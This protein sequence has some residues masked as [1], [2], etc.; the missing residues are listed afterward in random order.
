MIIAGV[1]LETTGLNTAED[2]I[3]EIGLVCWDTEKKIPLG[4]FSTFVDPGAD[5][6]PLKAEAK[7]KNKIE[8]E[9]LT[10][11]GMEPSTALIY[12]SEILH[13]FGVEHIVGHNCENYD[14]PL[15]MAEL[16]RNKIIGHLAERTPWIDSRT[17]CP[18]PNAIETRKLNHLAAEHGFINP[19]AHRAV[20]DVLTMLRIVSQ[21]DINEIIAQSKIPFVIIQ[22]LVSYD[23]RQKAKDARFNWE[24]IGDQ[25]FA[26]SWVKKIRANA[27][28]LEKEIANKN[29]YTIRE[30]C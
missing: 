22:A 8:E 9:W 16:K 19:F 23:D 14:K 3:I 6:L 5:F 15:F 18:Y 27:L 17:D 30:L 29:G 12:V 24:N 4:V 13:Q 7:E 11:F 2:R 26:K 10:K 28:D 1:D 21:Y 25:K 20:F